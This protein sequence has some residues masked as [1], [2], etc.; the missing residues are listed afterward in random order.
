MEHRILHRHLQEAAPAG[1]GALDEGYQN[2]DGHK[3]AGAGITEG[4]SRLDR[5]SVAFAG[6]A[7]GAARRLRDHVERQVLLVGAAG[8]KTLDLAID[9]ARVDLLDLIITEPEALDRAGCHI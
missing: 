7:D 6:D 1:P 9:N 5:C 8:A 3:H 4:G 2:A